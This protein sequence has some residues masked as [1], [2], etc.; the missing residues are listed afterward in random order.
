MYLASKVFATERASRSATE[1]ALDEF[2]AVYAFIYSRVANK[3]DAEDLTQQVALK[4]LPRREKGRTAPEDT[5]LSLR[6]GTL[7]ACHILE[8]PLAV[9]GIRAARELPGSRPA[10]RSCCHL[11]RRPPG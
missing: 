5:G 1:V 3:A 11:K 2:E 9:A 8:R 10:G 6:D 4:A 7:G